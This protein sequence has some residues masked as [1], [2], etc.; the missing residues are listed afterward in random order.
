MA[1]DRPTLLLTRR[2][3]AAVEARARRDYEVRQIESD[4]APP[5]E[6]I[7]AEAEGCDGVMC[8]AGDPMGAATLAGLPERVRI[9]STFSVGFDHV[10]L[11]A[12]RGRGLVV[13][14]TPD[15]LTTATA[16]IAMSLIL[17]AAR[18]L[19]EGERLVRARAWTGWTPTQL[20]GVTLEGKRLGVLGM[21]RIGRRLATMARGFGMEIHYRDVAPIPAE[22]AAGATFHG[23]DD[24][25]LSSVQFLSM[26][27]PGGE[28][29]RGWLSAE[30][31]AKLPRGAIVVNTG[32][33]TTV[34]DAA[35]CD[36]LRSGHVRAAGLDVY[37]GE[38]DLYPG[39]H[40]AP[41]LTMLPHLGSATEETR[42][43][44]GHR[45]LDNLDAVLRRGEDA[46]HRV[47]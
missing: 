15:V 25:F 33:G 21:G 31:I 1:A 10:D 20:M 5:A 39:Y 24:G 37:A 38:P 34:D 4:T 2:F 12:A 7:V 46:P 42:D 11:A 36:A 8:A 13:T 29:T 47:A 27:I 40:D 9:V 16:E 44:M 35:L 23:D 6:R 32:R 17:M 18:R 30:R 41:N 26:H 3:P 19:G 14:N 22:D 28:A 43:A 45:C